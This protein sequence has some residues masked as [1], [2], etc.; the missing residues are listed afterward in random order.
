[1]PQRINE[2]QRLIH[3]IYSQ[4]VPQGATVTESAMLKEP[5]SNS[6]REA[7]IL[8]EYEDG[9]TRIRMAGSWGVPEVL[10]AVPAEGAMCGWRVGR[11]HGR[12]GADEDT[13]PRA[14]VNCPHSVGE[15]H[16]RLS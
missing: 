7:D 8:V 1:M 11:P 14:R 13:P 16:E 5:T 9:G 12:T 4:M 3:A 15:C 2:F 6:M 10:G